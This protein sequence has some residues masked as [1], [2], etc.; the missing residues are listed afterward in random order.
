VSLVGDV[1]EASKNAISKT[2]T[3][4]SAACLITEANLCA[5]HLR[6]NQLRKTAVTVTE[7]HYLLTDTL[8]IQKCPELLPPSPLGA[9]DGFGKWASIAVIFGSVFRSVTTPSW[10]SEAQAQS[11]QAIIKASIPHQAARSFTERNLLIEKPDATSGIRALM[12]KE[13]ATKKFCAER[14]ARV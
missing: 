3:P 7:R 5:G 2:R 14:E 12:L 13:G 9:Y 6:C 1:Q 4:T 10:D 11:S 8:A